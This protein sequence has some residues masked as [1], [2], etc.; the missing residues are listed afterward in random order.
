LGEVRAAE[1]VED[2]CE[3]VNILEEVSVRDVIKVLCSDVDVLVA[4]TY[5]SLSAHFSFGQVTLG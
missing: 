4:V 3:G 5:K 1:V 2:I